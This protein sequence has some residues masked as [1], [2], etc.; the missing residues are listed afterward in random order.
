MSK[1]T[2]LFHGSQFVIEKPILGLGN[3]FNDY[4]SG[5]YCTM[6]KELAKEWA[7]SESAGGYANRYVLDKTGLRIMNLESGEYN[8]LNWLALLLNNRSFSISNDVAESA[9]EY[10]I[11]GFL[12]DIH[13]I[14]VI[15]GYRANDSYFAFANAFINSALSLAQLEEAMYLGKLGEQTVLM[16]EKAFG[17]ITFEGYEIAGHKI[18]YSRK[19][20]RD[21]EARKVFKQQRS[22]AQAMDAV[23]IMDIMRGGWGNDDPRLRRDLS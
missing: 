4:G 17:Q 13:D 11:S 15:I 19:M 5:F 1:Q 20:V 2:T 6:D 18:Y 9:K 3:P 10:L 12:P 14:D 7:C 16:S 23:Y 8:I 22:I 21:R